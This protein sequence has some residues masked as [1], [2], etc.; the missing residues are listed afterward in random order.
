MADDFEALG[1]S[2]LAPSNGGK[3]LTASTELK[4]CRAFSGTY[5]VACADL[6]NRLEP[7]NL[8]SQGLSQS[9]CCGPFFS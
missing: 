7:V 5:F 3:V 9:I 2:V 1:C 6:W 8:I 4:N